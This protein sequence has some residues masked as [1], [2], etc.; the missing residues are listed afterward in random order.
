[1]NPICPPRVRI[2]AGRVV[3]AVEVRARRIDG[4]APGEVD[5]RRHLLTVTD[6]FH[7]EVADGR[8]VFEGVPVLVLMQKNV[9]DVLAVVGEGVVYVG[10]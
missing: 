6:E 3:E 7:E 4:M 9:V 5:Q 8:L 2:E 10:T 1:M